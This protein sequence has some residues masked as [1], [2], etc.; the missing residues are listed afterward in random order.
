MQNN[1]DD[2]DCADPTSEL[3]QIVNGASDTCVRVCVY[4]YLCWAVLCLLARTLWE[5]GLKYNAVT[6]DCSFLKQSSLNTRS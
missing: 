1:N 4:E 5:W 6:G 3:S 2:G